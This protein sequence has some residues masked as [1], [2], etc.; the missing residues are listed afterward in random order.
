MLYG[1]LRMN[2]VDLSVFLVLIQSLF[3]MPQN[4]TTFGTTI[5]YVALGVYKSVLCVLF[6]MS[7][8]YPTNMFSYKCI[9]GSTLNRDL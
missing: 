2:I 4:H 3:N 1:K 8:I 5:H 6:K 9:G 7:V